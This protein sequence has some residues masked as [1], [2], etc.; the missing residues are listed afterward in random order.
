MAKR[1]IPKRTPEDRAKWQENHERLQRIIERRLA[2][3]REIHRHVHRSDLADCLGQ[4]SAEVFEHGESNLVGK[5]QV[6]I[7]CRKRQHC[8]RSVGNDGVFDAV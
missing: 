8:G 7:T 1:K 2:T 5:G 6:E 4:L 3:D